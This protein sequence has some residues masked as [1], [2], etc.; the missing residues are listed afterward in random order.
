MKRW[1]IVSTRKTQSLAE[2]S[3][4]VALIAMEVIRLWGE[5]ENWAGRIAVLALEHDLDEVIVGDIPTPAKGRAEYDFSGKVTPELVV[6]VADI[7]DAYTFIEANKIDRHGEHVARYMHGM[8]N[9]MLSQLT[10]QRREAVKDVV[11]SIFRGA[12]II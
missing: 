8:Y 10:S 5:P 9:R 11:T 7:I 4:N 3:F 1:H 12:Y 6:K 2:H